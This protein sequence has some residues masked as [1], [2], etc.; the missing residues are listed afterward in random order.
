MPTTRS[1]I[2][3]TCR[4]T[5]LQ[6]R[7]NYSRH[8]PDTM[9]SPKRPLHGTR[10][11]YILLFSVLG[12]LYFLVIAGYTH[13]FSRITKESAPVLVLVAIICLFNIF[14]FGLSALSGKLAAH[15]ALYSEH[16]KKFTL[17][18]I[19]IAVI[20]L[21]ANYMM[22]VGLKWLAGAPHPWITR[23]TGI[24]LVI[25]MWIA[26]MAIVTLLMINK[27]MSEMLDIY[28]E[29]QELSRKFENARYD[30]L[31][32]Q[33]DPHFLFNSLN[34]LIYE[35]EN[36]AD[37]A[38]RF[39]RNLADVY[40]YVLQQHDRKLVPLN[41]EL[42]FLHSYIFL[43]KVRLG[44][45]IT[46]HVDIPEEYGKALLPPLTLQLLAENAIKHNNI[47]ASAPM[48]IRLGADTTAMTLSVANTRRPKEVA[49][50]TGKGLRNLAERCRLSSGRDIAV[51][52]TDERFIVTV[53]VI[54]DSTAS[55]TPQPYLQSKTI[56]S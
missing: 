12:Y 46:L 39:T 51:C 23:Q 47:S 54:L 55:E 40:R 33:L 2:R 16:R 15:Y 29:K 35:I 6:N 32:S 37:N 41:E 50:T 14:G 26:E 22:F 56:Q 38:V 18:M 42:D 3:G 11:P 49:F 31:Q 4:S 28:R 21:A 34:T 5:A 19:E 52:E 45:C 27:S 25:L 10:W 24:T 13:M 7:N 9:N 20:L 36:D 43:H 17:R 53:P 44:D 48:T 8:Y 1:T 30:A